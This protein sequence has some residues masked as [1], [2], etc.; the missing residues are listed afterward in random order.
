MNQ[1]I[2]SHL[3][4]LGRIA[5]TKRMFTAIQT[6]TNHQK[7]LCLVITSGA[8][9]E[10]KTTTATGLAI[11]ATD[12]RR[13]RTL[14]VDY[15]WYAPAVHHF[16]NIDPI[17]SPAAFYKAASLDEL[18]V[19]T[20]SGIDI[21]P[22]ARITDDFHGTLSISKGYDHRLIQD[23]K[24]RYDTII[25]DTSSTFPENQR[26]RDPIL[27]SS[28]ADGV[29]LVFMTNRT[30]RSTLKRTV[31]AMRLSGAKLLGVVANQWKNPI[32]H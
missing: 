23:A 27:L 8:R 26:M 20:V 5:E 2:D 29:V 25:V 1:S 32:R 15:N 21:L 17:E 16:F 18:I 12:S 22:A 28:I 11:A 4:T 9:G 30:P 3:Y 19:P 24:T 13:R 10:G 14:L 7:N 31:T 6:A